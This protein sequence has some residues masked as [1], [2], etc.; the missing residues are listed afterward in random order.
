MNSESLGFGE[1]PSPHT[2]AVSSWD[3]WMRQLEALGSSSCSDLQLSRAAPVAWAGS[4]LK[5]KVFQAIACSELWLVEKARW[6]GEK[7]KT[8]R[9]KG[10]DIS[11]QLH[12][13]LRKNLTEVFD[14]RLPTT[15]RPGG[16]WAQD[17]ALK[18]VTKAALLSFT[19]PGFWSSAPQ[20]GWSRWQ[21][22]LHRCWSFTRERLAG[23]PERSPT[24]ELKR[25][26]RLKGARVGSLLV[27]RKRPICKLW[28][29]DSLGTCFLIGALIQM[30]P[31]AS[32]C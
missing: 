32:D 14:W 4:V 18:A 11:C 22:L 25:V 8:G 24:R 23:L 16:P 29:R 21:W 13:A 5:A 12:I 7:S 28:Q 20:R 31:K 26:F 30:G 19:R 2:K 27:C 6:E 15:F 9:K 10:F 17:S 1:A 3:A